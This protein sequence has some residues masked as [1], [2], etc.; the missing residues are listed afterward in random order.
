MES[1]DEPGICRG[2]R[3]RADPKE[4]AEWEFGVASCEVALEDDERFK[5]QVVLYDNIV[6]GEE[7]VRFMGWQF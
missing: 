4:R 5:F 7:G 3:V 6:T 2:G 1:S